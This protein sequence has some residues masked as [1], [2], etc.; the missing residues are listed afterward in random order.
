MIPENRGKGLG[1]QL[2]AYAIGFFRR[3]GINE[4]HL[5]VSPSNVQAIS[6]YLKNGMTKLESELDGKV[7]RMRG[8]IT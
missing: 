7:I 5:R 8:I 4:Y 1:K 6:F 2:H 3:R